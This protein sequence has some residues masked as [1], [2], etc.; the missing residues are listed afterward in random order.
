MNLAKHRMG[1]FK[2]RKEGKSWL[3]YAAMIAFYNYRGCI[4]LGDMFLFLAAPEGL[5]NKL[6]FPD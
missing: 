3:F 5:N 2:E 1:Q 4:S 6:T